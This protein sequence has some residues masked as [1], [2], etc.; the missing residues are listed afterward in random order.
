MNY[1]ISRNLEYALMALRYMSERKNQ[2]VS[3]REMAQVF[4]CPFHPFSRVLQK[5]ADH[6]LIISQKGIGGGYTFSA[7][8]DRLSMYELM[9]LVLPPTEIAAC[10]SGYCNLLDH[11]NI[12]N[13]I[14]Y[15]NKKFMEFY[16]TLNVKEILSC[17][18][19][20]TTHSKKIL[21]HLVSETSKIP[22]S[23]KRKQ[24]ELVKT[25]YTGP[26]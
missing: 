2:C 20:K 1:K 13:P 5:L 9:S 23:I 12:Q 3:A 14:H 25:Y 24:K 6:K 10:L 15:L 11:C 4:Q 8:L 19:G 22:K 26:V 18:D 16:K 21:N 7:N 17:G